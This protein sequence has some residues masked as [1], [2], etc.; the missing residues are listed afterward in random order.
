MSQ[1]YCSESKCISSITG[2]ADTVYF[3]PE[4]EFLYLMMFVLIHS[5]T[6][7]FILLIRLREDGTAAERKVLI[8]DINRDLRKDIS[9]FL[10]LIH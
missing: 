5:L 9:R 10:L 7:V 6:A 3:G 8:S 2:I 1:E 4:A